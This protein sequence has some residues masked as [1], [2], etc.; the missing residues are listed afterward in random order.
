[1]SSGKAR[2]SSGIGAYAPSDDGNR[3]AFTLD[4][5]GYRQYVLYV[6]D[7]RTGAVSAPMAVRVD[8]VAWSTDGSTLMYGQED[9]VTKRTYLALRQKL[10]GKPE[11]V[12]EEKDDLYDLTVSRTRSKGYFL[13]TSESATTTEVRYVPANQ[14]TDAREGHRAAHRRAGVR[15]RSRRQRLPHSHQRQG[16]HV[17]AGIG[18]GDEPGQGQLEGTDPEPPGHDARGRGRLLGSH[19]HDR[20]GGRPGALPG[21]ERSMPATRRTSASPSPPT[22]WTRCRTTSS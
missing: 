22:R 1:M 21:A 7:L 3:L 19:G 8:G 16:S 18:A 14:P 20:A 11:V 13:L 9:S 5:T 17:P 4:T 2:H 10:G 15:G 6:K 12:F